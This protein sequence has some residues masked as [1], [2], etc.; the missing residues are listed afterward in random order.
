[1]IDWKCILS[2]LINQKGIDIT[3][4]PT[5]WNLSNPSY[6]EIFDQVKVRAESK[7]ILILILIQLSGQIT[8]L[9]NI[10]ILL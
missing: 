1:M 8:I 5:L 10:T 7:K 4:D 9:I 2:N 6:K 3:T